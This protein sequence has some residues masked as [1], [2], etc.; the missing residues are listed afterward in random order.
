MMKKLFTFTFAS[1]L[2]DS[3]GAQEALSLEQCLR[4]GIEN[5]LGLQTRQNKVRKGRH[6]ISEN[7]AKPLPQVNA[8]AAYNDN[9]SHWYDSNDSGLTLR[10]PLIDGPDKRTK[11]RKAEIDIE[12]IPSTGR[13]RR[14]T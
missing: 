12:N 4:I 6:A 14:R 1:L 9:F 3:A 5:N 8:V 2:M 11:L 7:R 10:I 13:T